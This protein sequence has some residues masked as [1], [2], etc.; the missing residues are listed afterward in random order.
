MGQGIGIKQITQQ[1][2]DV[3]CVKKF[4][5]EEK[6]FRTTSKCITPR[7]KEDLAHSA[8]RCYGGKTDTI[9]TSKSARK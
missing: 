4:L 7:T 5:K 6:L 2:M 3:R 8:S 1:G 9:T